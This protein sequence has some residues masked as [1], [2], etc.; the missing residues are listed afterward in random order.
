MQKRPGA[1]MRS[2]LLVPPS[3]KPD[4]PTISSTGSIS[5]MRIS[6]KPSILKVFWQKQF[7]TAGGISNFETARR[8][9]L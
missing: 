2:G 5:E 8:R 6:R 3:K 1:A 9:L 7:L 4:L